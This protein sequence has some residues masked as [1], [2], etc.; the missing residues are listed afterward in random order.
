VVTMMMEE[1]PLPPPPEV[2]KPQRLAEQKPVEKPVP[3]KQ[4]AKADEQKPKPSEAPAPEQGILAFREKLA[5]VKEDP[6]LARL[7][8]QARINNSNQGGA[9]RPERFDADH[10]CAGLER[11]H[12]AR[13]IEP[14]FR[15]ERRQ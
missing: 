15:S 8:S 4:V 1:H 11:R 9:A 2:V 10:Q 3:P 5:A 12:Q 7:G 14:R 13:L 6:M